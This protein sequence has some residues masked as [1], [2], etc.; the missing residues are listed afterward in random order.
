MVENMTK[1]KPRSRECRKEKKKKERIRKFEMKNCAECVRQKGC[2]ECQKDSFFLA[3]MHSI[4]FL[5]DI[6]I[7]ENQ[8]FVNAL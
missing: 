1:L 2:T 3:N 8:I 6:L 7:L 5:R 4:Y